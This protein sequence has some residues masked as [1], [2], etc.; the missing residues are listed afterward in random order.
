[1][2]KFEK[3]LSLP[4]IDRSTMNQSAS[5]VS[6]VQR[7]PQITAIDFVVYYHQRSFFR[8][9]INGLGL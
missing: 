4:L 9:I 2:K 7:N 1:M 6:R 5:N 3:K 8:K